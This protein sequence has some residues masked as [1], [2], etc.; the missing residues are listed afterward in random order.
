M[1]LVIDTNIA[2][3]AILNPRGV[4]ADLLLNSTNRFSF[5][6]PTSLADELDKH[7]EKLKKIS[8]LTQNELNFLKRIILRKIELIDLDVIS[9]HAWKKALDLTLGV[10]EFDAPFIALSIELNAPLWTGDLKLKKGL[11]KSG[12][13]WILTTDIIQNIR[14][15]M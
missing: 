12:I 15:K 4:I 9:S 2:F 3:S 8:T 14:D 7:Y 6:A 5:F 1:I 13:D 10:D 11:E